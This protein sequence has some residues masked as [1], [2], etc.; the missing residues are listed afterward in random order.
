MQYKTILRL[1]GLLLLLYSFT[2]LPPMLINMIFS[3]TIWLP[4]VFPFILCFLLGLVLWG[5]FR[6]HQNL[7]KI[8][9]GFLIVV[10]IWFSISFISTIPF[11]CYADLH[12]SLTDIVFETVSGL[13]TTGAVVF[14]NLDQLPH[15]ILYYRQQLQFLGG[16]GI[17][18]LA[19]AIFPMLGMGGSQ[20]FRVETSGAMRDNK[21]T[22]RI[23][24]TAKALWGIYCIF[25]LAC[26]W[27]YWF[28]GMDWFYAIGESFA[29]MSTGGFSMHN[30]SFL[31]YH[32]FAIEIFASIFM[33]I[34]SISFSLHYVAFQRH[35]LA[36]YLR[37]EEFRFFIGGFLLISLIC[38]T[39]LFANKHFALSHTHWVDNLFMIISLATT[40]GFSLIPFDKWASFTPILIILASIVGGCAGSTTGGI[41]VLRVVFIAKQTKREFLRLLHPQAVIPIKIDEKTV[42]ESL[43]Q[44]ATTFVSLFFAVFALLI[45]IFMSLGND[46]ISSFSA[47]AAGLANS[48]AGVGTISSNFASLSTPSK[49]LLILTMLLG[50]LE[51]YP[52]FL[53]FTKPFWEK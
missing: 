24:Q 8:R 21:L 30:D 39:T 33:L 20:L 23:T 42:P 51:M 14:T 45:L 26:A 15:A 13:T 37:D 6:Q 52:L 3:E 27:C 10:I 43:L 22:P 28:C 53:L 29:T 12:L 40:T 7:L 38:I 19:V 31:Y 9:E 32:S 17:I 35:T 5:M 34:G 4:F 25:T 44:S 36:T 11:L 49:W 2:M 1:I 47:I 18:V 46:F 16:M 50:R 41:K 48:G